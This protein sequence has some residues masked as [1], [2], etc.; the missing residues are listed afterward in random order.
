M[1]KAEGKKLSFRETIRSAWGP[2]RRLYS[3]AGPYK[4]RFALGLAFGVAYALVT[5]IFPITVYRVS[6]FV[7][8]SGAPS[9]RTALLHQELLNVGPKIDSI[10]WICLAIPVIMTIRSLCTYGGAYYMA[11]VGTRSVNDFGNQFFRKLM[12]H[13]MI[14]LTRRK[15]GYLMWGIQNDGETMH[16]RSRASVPTFS[17]N[18]SRL[19]A[20]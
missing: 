18:R 2:Y 1:S 10:V 7:F 11:L 17:N 14:F 6:S 19:S 13:S 4:W 9:P 20:R 3:Y 5:S 8:P 15:A 12:G 16:Q